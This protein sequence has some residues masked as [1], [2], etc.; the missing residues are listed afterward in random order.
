MMKTGQSL[1]EKT[2]LLL[3]LQQV[4]NITNLLEGNNYQN[5]IY[6]SLISIQCE[7]KRQLTHFID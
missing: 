1:S 7:L 5:F 4:D 6:F 2:K 3:A